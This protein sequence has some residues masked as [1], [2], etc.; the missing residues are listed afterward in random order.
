MKEKDDWY[1]VDEQTRRVHLHLEYLPLSYQSSP[2]PNGIS[3]VNQEFSL[4]LLIN[5]FVKRRFCTSYTRTS[6]CETIKRER[7]NDI[8]VL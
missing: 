8:D 6:R 7:E 5:A 2:L 1:I 3:Y 4:L